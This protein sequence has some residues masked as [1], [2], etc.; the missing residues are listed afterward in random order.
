MISIEPK[1]E[2]SFTFSISKEPGFVNFDYE[3]NWISETVF[4]KTTKE[5][6]QQLAN[7]KDVLAKQKALDALVEITKDSVTSS[8]VKQEIINAFEK[9][10]N[11]KLYWRYRVYAIGSLRKIMPVPYDAETIS[12][13]Q[14][15][16]K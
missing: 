10:I 11:A 12:I 3:E 13:L 7:S 6:L 8:P 5:W 16:I 1:A 14:N 4:E 2:N 9:E 15:I